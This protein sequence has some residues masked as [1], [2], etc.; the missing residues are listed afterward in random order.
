MSDLL[1]MVTCATFLESVKDD[2]F[3]AVQIHDLGK[4][5]EDEGHAEKLT[6]FIISLESR[7]SPFTDEDGERVVLEAVEKF[8]ELIVRFEF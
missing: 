2:E 1:Q 4:W 6:R 5:I 3:A 8:K 7:T